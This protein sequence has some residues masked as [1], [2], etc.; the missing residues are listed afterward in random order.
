MRYLIQRGLRG[1]VE[2]DGP[3]E[4]GRGRHGVN[5]LY[6][7]PEL[8]PVNGETG[9]SPES[10]LE[11]RVLSLD[12]ETDPRA[13]RLLSIALHGCGVS[14]VLLFCPEG[15]SCPE[16]AQGFSSE[17]ELLRA[18]ARRVRE[19][20]PD[21]LTGWSVIDFDLSVLAS[22]A[23]R[24]GVSLELGRG[25]GELRLRP[26]RG[27]RAQTQV[28][29]PGRLVLDGP[30]LLRGAFVRLER[31]SLDFAAREILGEGKV[32]ADD[33]DRV[34]D[35]KGAEILRLFTDDRRTFVDYNRT[36]A[37]LALEIL[38]RLGLIRLAMQRSRL[39]GL[40]MDRVSG[41]IAA[42]DSLYLSRLSRR[43]VVAPTVRG[44][45]EEMEEGLSTGGHVL[46][47]LPGLWER[48]LTFD[49]KSLYPSLIRTFQIDPLGYLPDG[50]GAG[51]DAIL[52]PNGAA[53]RRPREGEKS[54]L[55]A[56][57]DQLFPRREAAQKAGDKVADQAIKIL[58][59]SFYGVLG[60]PACRF[61]NPAL[62]NA[63]TGFGR[64][65]LLWS[66]AWF[67][68]AGHRVLYGDTDSLF[69]LSEAR[70]DAEALDLGA[71]LAAEL[72]R[73]L[74]RHVDETWGVASRL[75]LQ[76]ERLYLKLLL[77]ATR[78]STASGGAAVGARKRYAGLVSRE[79]AGG[80]PTSEVVFVGMEAVRRDWTDL[81][82]RVQRELYDRL[83]SER[84]VEDYLRRT[85]A[86]LRAG[87]LDRE[88]VYRKALRKDLAAYTSTSPP[89]VAAARKAS[90]TWGRGRLIAYVQ[91]QAGPEPAAERTSAIDHEHYLEKQV[92]P[93]AEPVLDL[94]GLE[95]K[96][97][98][99][100]DRQLDL[101]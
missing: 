13:R 27:P 90:G 32:Q 8:R 71:R 91:T 35:D 86:R 5:R 84:P 78:G 22:M 55:P 65:I 85:T 95:F 87:E 59:N 50:A 72:N 75:E 56:L 93:I 42:F 11:P 83:F 25:P 18:F 101:F 66:K 15:Y 88:L 89:H 69:V 80:E 98:V 40:P 73:E 99:G 82:R 4:N 19:L 39:T 21:I 30:H 2:I 6:L 62:A 12:I 3:W 28:S 49:F 53:F 43:G 67:E 94:L 36:D 46:E 17:R 51:G 26:G 10:S 37:R 64:E 33:P 48:V 23:E 60:T 31:Y 45:G 63:I 100:D 34:E 44:W 7:N 68:A 97:V 29:L 74:S 92:R 79:G 24:F 54:I 57:L 20:D 16:D 38:E 14:E 47:P 76:L 1:L 81:A 58:M 52:A 41:S 61:S 96:K 77:P 9:E 70:S